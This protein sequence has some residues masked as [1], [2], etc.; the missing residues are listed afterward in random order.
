M[1]FKNNLKQFLIDLDY[2]RYIFKL[3]I[4]FDLVLTLL[5]I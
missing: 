1:R 5:N 4:T 3:K 2:R